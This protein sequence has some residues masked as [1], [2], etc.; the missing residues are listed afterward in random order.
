MGIKRCSAQSVEVDDEYF[1]WL[2]RLVEAGDEYFSLL[3]EMYDQEFTDRTAKF[4][5]HDQ[6]RVCDAVKLRDEFMDEFGYGEYGGIFANAC[7]CLELLIS[8]ASAM[9]D[10]FPFKT[11]AEFF[12]EMAGNLGLDKYTEE[13][14]STPCGID[15]VYDILHDWRTR[16]YCKD[17]RGC[18][19]PLKH[20]ET[21]MRKTEIWYQLNAY[22]IENYV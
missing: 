2:C 14:Y 3:R 15:E 21:D 4:V 17:G 7:S 18:P 6:N 20:A 19:F 5:P 11:R 16:E 12:W 1:S 9:E 8:L 13:M 22:L 10:I